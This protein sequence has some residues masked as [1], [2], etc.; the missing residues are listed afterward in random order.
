MSLHERL[1]AALKYSESHLEGMVIIVNIEPDGQGHIV[2]NC[3]A[4]ETHGA[5]IGI[6]SSIMESKIA[7][8]THK[9]DEG[10]IN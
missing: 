9:L 2:S 1:A 5:M 3:D 4:H 10:K 7:D 8:V 6:A